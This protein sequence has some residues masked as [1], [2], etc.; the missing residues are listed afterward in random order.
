MIDTCP[1]G[2]SSSYNNCCGLYID[3]NKNLPETAEHLMRSRY[4][5]YSLANID[6]IYQTMRGTARKG[7]SKKQALDWASTV[8]WQ[9][10]EII[11]STENTVEFKAYYQYQGQ[12]EV[13]HEHS[14]FEKKNGKW[15]YTGQIQEL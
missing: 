15:F 14:Q 4:T 6:Y 11:S 3:N 8:E 7:F 13:L 5:A 1:C 12:N 10:L 2:S 9:R